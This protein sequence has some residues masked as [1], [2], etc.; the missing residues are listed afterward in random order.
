[1]TLD[2]IGRSERGGIKQ[3]EGEVLDIRGIVVTKEHRTDLYS[4]KGMKELSGK[5][6]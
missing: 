6:K 1:M 4:A 2:S 3:I 5:P